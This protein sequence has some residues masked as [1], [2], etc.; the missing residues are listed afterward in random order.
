MASARVIS[1]GED[2]HETILY[3]LRHGATEASSKAAKLQVDKTFPLARLQ[4]VRRKPPR[5]LAISPSIAAIRAS[6]APQTATIGGRMAFLPRLD[7]I[8]CDVGEWSDHWPGMFANER[9][10][11][12]RALAIVRDF[13]Y[14]AA[15]I[16]QRCTGARRH[17]GSVQSPSRAFARRSRRNRTY[18]A[19]LLGPGL[20][21]PPKVTLDNAAFLI[22]PRRKTDQRAYAEAAPSQDWRQVMSVSAS[23]ESSFIN[24][25]PNLR[26]QLGRKAPASPI[27]LKCRAGRGGAS[28]LRQPQASQARA[29]SLRSITVNGCVPVKMEGFCILQVGQRRAAVHFPA[30]S[31]PLV[32]RIT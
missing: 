20:I 24:D 28:R 23:I 1:E 25:S 8:E 14:Q 22:N 11:S 10:K 4:I 5:F 17:R 30:G 16:V 9:R 7:D 21:R 13:G 6:L 12:I 18:L 15:V 3:L 2:P 27:L 19:G 32:E 29:R 26:E 31:C